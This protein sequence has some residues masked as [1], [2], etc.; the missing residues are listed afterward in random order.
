MTV[1]AALSN[2]ELASM[3][4][5]AGGMYVYLRETY[6]PLWGFLYGWTFFTVVQTGTIAAVSAAFARFLAVLRPVV[7]ENRY[8]VPPIAIGSHYALSLS[9]AQCLAIGVIALLTWTNSRGLEYGGLVQDLFT[10]AKTVALGALIV[11][12]LTLA[13]NREAVQTNFTD[14]WRT[15]Q[16]DSS[17]GVAAGSAFGLIVALC[18]AQSGSQVA[19]DSWHNVTFIAAEVREPRRNV[20]V[21]M[22]LGSII[23]IALYLLANVAYLAALPLPAIQRAPS[24]RV[25]TA[26]LQRIFP[27]AGTALMA[28]AIMI[29]TFG[30][31]N[32]LVLAGRGP[33]TPWLAMACSFAPL[34]C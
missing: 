11:L 3:M 16:F 25:A 24:D 30:C 23:V 33:I 18:T 12:G 19:A 2:G 26:M 22:A 13:W 29:S 4:P 9:T 17:L 27:G 5:Q 14:F 15:G 32:S 10:S 1:S 28:G 31:V 8:L 21:A 6:S 20:P 34:E 7:G